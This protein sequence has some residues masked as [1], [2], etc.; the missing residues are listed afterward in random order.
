MYFCTLVHHHHQLRNYWSLCNIK[1]INT[2]ICTWVTNGYRRCVKCWTFPLILW[3]S[4]WESV[5]FEFNCTQDKTDAE[6]N[7]CSCLRTIVHFAACSII[8]VKALTVTLWI[9][10][11]RPP[12][13]FSRIYWLLI[14]IALIFSLINVPCKQ[15][16]CTW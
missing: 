1:F 14:N 12:L 6:S 7:F 8:L 3:Q 4:Y 11:L 13:H 9:L 5:I 10:L 15:I 2:P 16:Q